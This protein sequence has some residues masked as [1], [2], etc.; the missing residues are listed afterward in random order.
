MATIRA[1]RSEEDYEAALTRIDELMDSLSGPDGQI[2]DVNHPARVDLDLLADL[3]ELYEERQH[4]IGFPDPISAIKF[5]MDQADLSPRDLAPFI[6]SSAK[7][8]E[9]LSGKR[10]I[11]MSMARALHR[12]LGIPAEVLLQ[13]PAANSPDEAPAIEYGRFPLKA[14]AKAGWIPWAKDLKDRAEELITDLMEQAGGRKFAAAALYRKNDSRRV[15][16][17]TDDYALRAWCWKVL[18]QANS[19]ESAAALPTRRP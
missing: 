5:R 12:H 18:A 2:D 7:V 15:N 6:G 11:T 8:S 4:P 3:V 17:K 14:M 13:E 16:A 19:A 1:I 9:V 10:A